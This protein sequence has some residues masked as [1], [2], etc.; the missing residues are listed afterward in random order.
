[1][2][3][4]IKWVVRDRSSKTNRQSNDKKEKDKNANNSP[5]NVQNWPTWTSLRKGVEIRWSRNS[6]VRAKLAPIFPLASVEIVSVLWNLRFSRGVVSVLV[7]DNAF[8]LQMLKQKIKR[9]ER[10]YKWLFTISIIYMDKCNV[11]TAMA[12]TTAIRHNILS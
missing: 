4:G 10:N 9:N 5:Q 12:L 1:M 2:I 3:V 11:C 8:I 7:V 6:P